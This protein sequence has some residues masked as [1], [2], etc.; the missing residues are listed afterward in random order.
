M[1][2]PAASL[3][4]DVTANRRL[5]LLVALAGG[6]EDALL[7]YSFE[8]DQEGKYEQE[9]RRG[10]LVSV[11]H[12]HCG[13]CGLLRNRG[14][15]VSNWRHAA[16]LWVTS[17]CAHVAFAH[18]AQIILATQRR[19]PAPAVPDAREAPGRSRLP[20]PLRAPRYGSRSVSRRRYGLDFSSTA[21]RTE[22]A[23]STRRRIRGQA[24]VPR[25]YSITAALSSHQGARE[26]MNPSL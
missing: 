23:D 11:R 26:V 25:N 15:R 1:R 13:G 8:H 21:S 14:Q 4:L 22:E 9:R 6:L 12:V 20:C 16:S 10:G 7:V 24:L 2:T 18:G 17:S 3:L 5:S 19:R